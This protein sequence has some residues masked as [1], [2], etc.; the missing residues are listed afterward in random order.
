M[1]R[2]ARLAG[3]REASWPV[4]LSLN[5]LLPAASVS[6]GKDGAVSAVSDEW[7]GGKAKQR[8]GLGSPSSTKPKLDRLM[9]RSPD[10]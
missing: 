7:E 4:L 2:R 1:V 3:A 5:C 9:L 8:S 6:W 10:A